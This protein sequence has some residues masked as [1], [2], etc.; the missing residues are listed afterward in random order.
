MG[1]QITWFVLWGVL[2][3]VYFMLDGFV[4]GSG[5]LHPVLGKSDTDR[6]ILINTIGP[7]W[8][9]NEVWLIT[10]GGATFAAFPTTYALMFSN[11]YSALIL[12]LFALIAYASAWL[13]AGAGS[14]PLPAWRCPTTAGRSG[15]RGPPG[16][17]PRRP[18]G[19]WSAPSRATRSCASG[20][21]LASCTRSGRTSP[22]SATRW[23]A[24]R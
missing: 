4:L 23:R 10:A 24:I 7:V 6:R 9:G 13:R 18:T 19:R 14:R 3:A 1:Y 15:T 8:D 11:L 22:T 5:I 16:R 20:S 2:W 17:A 21:S 12:L